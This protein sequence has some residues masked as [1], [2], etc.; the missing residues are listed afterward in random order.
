MLPQRPS[1]PRPLPEGYAM[2][3][4]SHRQL[5]SYRAAALLFILLSCSNP[6]QQT[7]AA[8]TPNLLIIQTDE[9]HFR[10]LSCYG[11]KIVK[12]THIDWLASHGAR[13]TSYY[14]TTPVCSPSRASLMS[15]LYPQT[16]DV[17]N[18]NIPMNSKV[19]TFAQVLKSKGY[20]TGYSGKWHLDGSAKPGWAPKRN[21]GFA[22]NRYMF[23]RGH[24]KKLVLK[25]GNGRVGAT[26]KGKPSYSLDGADNKT[27]ATDW[28]ADRTIDFLNDNKGKSFCYMV[29][30][31]DPHG[32]NTVRAPYDT[33]YAN[34]K[35]P[36]PPTLTK[37]MAQ[38]PA[39]ARIS[40]KINPA[41]L[42]RL[43][44]P[45]YGMVKCIDDNVGRIL[46]TLK[47][48][49]QLENTIIVFTSDHGD[50]C[51]EHGRLNK[52]I[53]YEG[54]ARIPFVLYYQGQVKAG[55]VIN[56]A[57]GTVDFMPTILSMMKINHNTKMQGRDASVFFTG[58]A[59]NAWSD[60]T[61]VRG[62]GNHS[63]IAAISQKHKLVFAPNEKPWLFDIEKDPNELT[64]YY[65]DKTY[66]PVVQKL[67][68]AL[69]Q[70]GKTHNDP[71]YNAEQTKLQ[72]NAAAK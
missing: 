69:M 36:I 68:R 60:I 37:T 9:H 40:K 61:F 19:T 53:A 49:K 22:D 51:G 18:N 67:S 71:S 39:W 50:L 64:N 38:T 5:F 20:A 66:Q 10:T 43:M 48:N 13:C 31:P 21:F 52:G 4:A 24:W 41:T 14:A 65:S 29:S 46:N 56:Q 33:M 3:L 54:S 30:I 1:N 62:T 26:T 44:A 58:E 8:D 59:P 34:K 15:G 55:T 47:Q 12:T 35:L 45:Y 70:Y 27:F 25:D 32:P 28:L 23:N 63:W 42:T 72:I 7:L 57:L 16:T 17:V 6:L 2:Q 11:G